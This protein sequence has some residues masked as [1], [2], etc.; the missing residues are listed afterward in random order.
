L[1]NRRMPRWWG[2]VVTLLLIL[3][4]MTLLIIGYWRLSDGLNGIVNDYHNPFIHFSEITASHEITDGIIYLVLGLLC[5]V[6]F[7][8]LFFMKREFL[9]PPEEP[10]RVLSEAIACGAL[11]FGDGE[12]LHKAFLSV[13]A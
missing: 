8:M 5:F 12:K 10:P 13:F 3:G 6:A 1:H 11:S 7:T 4:G 2:T 9:F